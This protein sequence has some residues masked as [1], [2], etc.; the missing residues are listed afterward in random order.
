M[1]MK[2]FDRNELFDLVSAE[3]TALSFE[4][5]T[6]CE[7]SLF[8]YVN[9]SEL[10]EKLKQIDEDAFLDMVRKCAIEMKANFNE[11]EELNENGFDTEDD[12]WEVRNEIQG[13]IMTCIEDYFEDY[14][15][16]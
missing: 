6:G 1:S 3:H 4:K 15:E 13:N 7:S 10:N 11:L 8:D 9:E 14:I 2:I 5:E 12:F 16:N